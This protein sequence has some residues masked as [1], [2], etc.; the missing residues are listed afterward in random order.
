MSDPIIRRTADGVEYELTPRMQE[1]IERGKERNARE[2]T[3]EE[4]AEV[5]EWEAS[6]P[7]HT[8]LPTGEEKFAI[9]VPRK[10]GG[11]EEVEEEEE[12]G[13]NVGS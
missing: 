1:L 13:D 4:L 7:L 12:D 8:P 2:L 6:L 9:I 11:D 10:N 5:E 3:D